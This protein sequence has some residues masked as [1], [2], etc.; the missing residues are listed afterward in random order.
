MAIEDVMVALAALELGIVTA[1]G[2]TV[3][4]AYDAEVEQVFPRGGATFV[5]KPSVH[6]PFEYSASGPSSTTH[7][8]ELLVFVAPLRSGRGIAEARRARR[9]WVPAIR[10]AFAAHMKLDGLMSSRPANYDC[11]VVLGPLKNVD[12]PGAARC[13]ARLRAPSRSRNASW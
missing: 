12:E 11:S 8:V 4:A 1:D 7:T 13:G 10:N 3:G 5:N 2:Q 9:R 6:G